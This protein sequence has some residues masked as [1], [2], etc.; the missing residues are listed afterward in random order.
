[1]HAKAVSVVSDSLRPNGL[2]PT[3]LLCPWDSPGKNTRVGFH[4]L[5]QGTFP[6][7]KVNPGGLSLLRSQ[8]LYS[9]Q[10]L[11]SPAEAVSASWEIYLL[12]L[13]AN[14]LQSHSLCLSL[15]TREVTNHWKC[16]ALGA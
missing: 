10:L 2:Q 11:E 13:L 8:I 14:V 12:A 4:A 16:I 5:L 9:W 15:L 1:M 3:R 6:V 7:H